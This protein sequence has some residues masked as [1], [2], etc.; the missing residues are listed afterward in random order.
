MFIDVSNENLK[1][2]Y[3]KYNWDI[4]VGIMGGFKYIDYN[5][6]FIDKPMEMSNI[7]E[8]MK[9][10]DNEIHKYSNKNDCLGIS[11]TSVELPNVPIG[12]FF[13]WDDKNNCWIYFLDENDKPSYYSNYISYD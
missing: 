13:G 1:S 12:S 5:D 10:D 11:K 9:I 4:S 2:K 7:G 6:N 3:K 8:I